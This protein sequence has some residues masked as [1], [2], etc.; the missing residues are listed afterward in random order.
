[1]LMRHDP[2]EAASPRPAAASAPRG[3]LG[4]CSLKLRWR[5]QRAAVTLQLSSVTQPPRIIITVVHR[6]YTVL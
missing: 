3:H 4:R 5:H 1:M 6:R 2:P